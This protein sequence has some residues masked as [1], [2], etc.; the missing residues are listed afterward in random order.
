MLRGHQC[1]LVCY[2]SSGHCSELQNS[3][4]I[5]TKFLCQMPLSSTQ[6]LS[7][8]PG[9]FTLSPCHKEIRSCSNLN[10][11]INGMV[12]VAQN[13]FGWE[14]C[15]SFMAARKKSKYCLQTLHSFLLTKIKYGPEQSKPSVELYC[16]AAVTNY[17][18]WIKK[19]VSQSQL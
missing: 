4:R 5:P 18:H 3:H 6:L 17:L 16:Y 9:S 11:F 10:S 7:T 19:Q 8:S 1:H 14:E 12:L 2:L 13:W 15:L